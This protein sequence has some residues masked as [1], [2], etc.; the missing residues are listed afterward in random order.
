M[1]DLVQQPQRIDVRNELKNIWSVFI[2]EILQ[3]SF[4]ENGYFYEDG[5]DNSRETESRSDAE[6][7]LIDQMEYIDIVG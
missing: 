5:F 4:T 1:G 3:N 2:I 6:Y 7:V